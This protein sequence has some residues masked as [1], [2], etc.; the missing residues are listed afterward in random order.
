MWKIQ[1]LTGRKPG[2]FNLHPVVRVSTK[3]T[4]VIKEEV[5]KCIEGFQVLASVVL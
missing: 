3:A 4:C 1:L 5:L 2:N